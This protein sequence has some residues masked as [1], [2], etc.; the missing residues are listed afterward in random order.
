MSDRVLTGQKM[1]WHH[2]LRPTDADFAYLAKH[3]RFDI[4]DAKTIRLSAP[5]SRFD[6]YRDYLFFTFQIP[7]VEKGTGLIKA[8]EL[9][10]YLG[11]N[12]LVTLT[13]RPLDCL[14][15]FLSRLGSENKYRAEIFAQG[16]AFILYKLLF[17]TYY[18]VM[19]LINELSHQV[20]KL[21]E[22]ISERDRAKTTTLELG[23]VRRNILHLRQIIDPQRRL[24]ASLQKCGHKTVSRAAALYYDDILDT[25]DSIWL[26]ADNLKLIVDGLFDVNEAMLS[27]KTNDVVTILTVISATLMVPTFISGFYGMNVPWLPYAHDPTFLAWLYFVSISTVMLLILFIFRR[28]KL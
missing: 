13:N 27:H 10:V 24:I 9:Q 19:P 1:T 20:N 28:R 8:E 15:K 22:A 21:E 16:Q 6:I 23:R 12:Y 4:A 7:F 2:Y 5:I 14:E 17:E 11:N 3:Y 25:I 18:G 26:T